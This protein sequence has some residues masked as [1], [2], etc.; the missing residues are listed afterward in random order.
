MKWATVLK[1]YLSPPT[2]ESRELGT[3]ILLQSR[4][5]HG[6]GGG[7]SPHP[8]FLYTPWG[9]LQ[10]RKH[11]INADLGPD[12]EIGLGVC[13]V[14]LDPVFSGGPGG[15]FLNPQA[16]FRKHCRDP[17]KAGWTHPPTWGH[18]L[19]LV[20]RKNVTLMRASVFI[21]RTWLPPG[22][23][24]KAPSQAGLRRAP[25]TGSLSERGHESGWAAG[26]A[27]GACGCERGLGAHGGSQVPCSDKGHSDH[28]S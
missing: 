12:P 10:P 9:Y 25:C 26:R 18:S 2:Q 8:Y 22:G 28:W 20:F 24:G 11:V 14:D 17:E 5:D 19:C 4:R 3:R 1:W 21:T 6:K 27:D 7:G 13:H 16:G 15:D 23:P